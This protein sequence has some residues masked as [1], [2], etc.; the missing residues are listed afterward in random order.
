MV[1]LPFRGKW[2]VRGIPA[3]VVEGARL[4]CLSEELVGIPI[5]GKGGNGRGGNGRRVRV[6]HP[7]SLNEL[8]TGFQPE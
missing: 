3:I 1:Y 6:T 7:E 4:T 8:V 2:W 5:I